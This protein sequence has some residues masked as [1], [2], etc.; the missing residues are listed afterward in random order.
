MG[1]ETKLREVAT[2]P[3]SCAAIQSGRV[4]WQ[5]S[6]EVQQKEVHWDMLGDICVETS[7]AE[8]NLAV[9]VPLS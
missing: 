2:L 4:S 1:G 6:H 8:K 3:E 9:L 5:E 7:S